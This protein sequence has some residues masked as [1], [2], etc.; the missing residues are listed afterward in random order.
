MIKHIAEKLTTWVRYKVGQMVS[1]HV[2]GN[3]D[4]DVN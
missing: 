2:K 4:E 3:T 1:I